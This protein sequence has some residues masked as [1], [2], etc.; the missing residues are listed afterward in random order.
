MDSKK[1]RPF[2][3]LK[4]WMTMASRA[5]GIPA[6]PCQAARALPDF[7]VREPQSL[8]IVCREFRTKAKPP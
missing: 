1:T 7:H 4:V 5:A 8:S 3:A 6:S 2:R